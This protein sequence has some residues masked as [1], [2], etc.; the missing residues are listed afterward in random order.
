[1]APFNPDP[2]TSENQASESGYRQMVVHPAYG[3]R[4]IVSGYGVLISGQVVSIS[5]QPVQATANVSGQ[6]VKIS[7]ETVVLGGTSV[8]QTSG[9]VALVSGQ[10]V[11]ISGQA[12]TIGSISVS[13]NVVQISGQSVTST[14]NIS[15][16]SVLLAA[17]DVAGLYRELTTLAS[18]SLVLRV[19]ALADD[20][21]ARISGETVSLGG[22]SVVK[23]SGE[24][25]MISGQFLYAGALSG[26]Y[27]SISG[28]VTLGGA[29]VV[30]V[31]GEVVQISGQTVTVGSMSVS[32][33]VVQTSG[34][35]AAEYVSLLATGFM[36]LVSGVGNL[37]FTGNAS[38]LSLT[39][40]NVASYT[41]GQVYLGFLSTVTVSGAPL[42]LHQDDSVSTT[43]YTGP[44][45][46]ATISGYPSTVS[47]AV[48]GG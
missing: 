32:G 41:S 45:F 2:W 37:L 8:V 30:K 3:W 9:Q 33:N 46:Y 18:G 35:T 6:P 5:G 20:L 44:W 11:Q 23:T 39:V 47:V 7:G 17:K 40:R 42:M 10:P 36:T 21:I 38:R 1:M 4:N 28:T 31:S 14:A 13:G 12:V 29:S 22:T 27:M 48:V 43:K 16:Q 26:Q 24:V 25:A 34:Q 19:G 15:G